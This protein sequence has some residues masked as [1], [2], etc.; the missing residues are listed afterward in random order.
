LRQYG[1][2]AKKIPGLLKNKENRDFNLS[3]FERR[4][5]FLLASGTK[6]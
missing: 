3:P 1:L 2:V 5:E 4:A 6:I